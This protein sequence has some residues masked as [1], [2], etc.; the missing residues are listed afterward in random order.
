MA[1]C[2]YYGVYVS[3][4]SLVAIIMQLHIFITCDSVA[5]CLYLSVVLYV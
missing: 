2:D 3:C 4:M 5:T 1:L